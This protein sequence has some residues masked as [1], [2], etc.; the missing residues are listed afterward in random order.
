MTR[1]WI[2]RRRRRLTTMLVSEAE[3]QAKWFGLEDA[4]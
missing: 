3:E 1:T 4:I 2:K